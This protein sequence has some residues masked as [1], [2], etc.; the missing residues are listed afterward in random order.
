MGAHRRLFLR[1]LLFGIFLMSVGFVSV[2]AAQADPHGVFFTVVG[3]QQLF[4]NIL[5]ALNQAD[6]VEP[7]NLRTQLRQRRDEAGY[8]SSQH[9]ALTTTQT[10]L[11]D[12]VTRQVSLEGE[13]VR[14]QERADEYAREVVRQRQA[15]ELIAQYCREAFGSEDCA[16]LAN[17]ENLPVDPRQPFLERERSFI[18]DPV[19]YALLPLVYGA[20]GVLS[21]GTEEHQKAAELVLEEARKGGPVLPLAYS[22]QVAALRKEA[23][24]HADPAVKDFIEN[25]I[26]GVQQDVVQSAPSTDELAEFVR[27]LRIDEN[28]NINIEAPSS[29]PEGP[30]A[31]QPL[32][33]EQQTA[34]H[35]NAQLMVLRLQ[36]VLRSLAEE[37]KQRV[38]L[39]LAAVDGAVPDRLQKI[40]SGYAD[41]P[42]G[43]ISVINSAPA[44]VKVGLQQQLL[45]SLLT[46]T[47][48]Q[49]FAD[50]SQVNVPSPEGVSAVDRGNNA[51]LKIGTPLEDFQKADVVELGLLPQSGVTEKPGLRR[52]FLQNI[53]ASILN[54]L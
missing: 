47:G 7:L 6:Y 50:P 16:A 24:N 38:A 25:L 54:N 36:R 22:R 52:N 33:P 34:F 45:P 46:L 39:Q 43:E 21:S 19:G 1:A 48:N 8:A 27:Q 40:N 9:S 15:A 3:Q 20:G 51:P 44:N 37:G 32:T 23:A 18:Q 11:A 26:L 30:D 12:V 28:G 10:D 49:A 31:G 42:I 13:D 29:I 35:A 2:P 53:L 4:F 17:R 41:D 5:A 14:T